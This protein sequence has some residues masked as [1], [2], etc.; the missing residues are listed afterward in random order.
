MTLKEC[1][2]I[3]GF[4]QE[5]LA[6]LVDISLRHYQNIEAGKAQPTIEIGLKLSHYLNVDP[7]ILFNVKFDK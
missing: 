4:S 5:K 2:L 6:R 1:R 7:F 3:K